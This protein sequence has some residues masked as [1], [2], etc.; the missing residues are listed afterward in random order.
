[1]LR[2]LFKNF[3]TIGIFSLFFFLTNSCL[4]APLELFS[5]EDN[6]SNIP[7]DSYFEWESTPGAVKYILDID[8]FTQSE[9]NILAS[10]YCTGGTCV[11]YFL[12]LSVGSINYWT[13]YSWRVTAYD[14]DDNPDTSGI[15]YFTTEQEPLTDCP[16]VCLT[17]T[18][19]SNISGICLDGYDCPPERSCC[20]KTSDGGGGGPIDLE[21]PLKF[22]SLWDAIN[23]LIDFLF[24]LVVA[25]APVF[26]IYAAFLLLT[27]HGDPKQIKKAKTIIFWT[28]I[29]LAVVLLAKGLPSVIK[30][31]MGG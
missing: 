28:A 30:Q 23:A 13:D 12:D 20:C 27:A 29:A 24:Y 25:L 10:D 4:A 16:H 3:L 17:E 19:C 11:F 2:K 6:S 8:Q 22:D 21:N 18:D 9:D 15:Y 1:M 5:P 14:A 31:A 7:T 26:V